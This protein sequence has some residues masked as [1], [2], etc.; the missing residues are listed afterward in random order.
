MANALC[1][2]RERQRQIQANQPVA[3]LPPAA[4]TLHKTA[5]SPH[6]RESL[7]HPSDRTAALWCLSSISE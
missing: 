5:S 6:G 3:N 4:V 7:Q 1:I 2:L